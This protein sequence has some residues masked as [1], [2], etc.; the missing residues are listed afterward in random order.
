MLDRG[1]ELYERKLPPGE[2]V[3]PGL[4]FPLPVHPQSPQ[5]GDSWAPRGSPPTR[6]ARVAAGLGRTAGAVPPPLYSFDPATGRL[7]VTTPRYNT[8]I[9]AVTHGA[10][11]YGGIDLARLFDDRQNVAATLGAKPPSSFGVI[12]R[13]RRGRARLVTARP[14]SDLYKKPALRLVRAPL[15]VGSAGSPL[16]PFAG[17]STGSRC[18]ARRQARGRRGPLDLHL[19]PQ[20]DRRRVVAAL[21][22]E[23]APSAEV[24]FPSTGGDKAAVW[25]ILKGGT[26]IQ[27]T[28]PRPHAGHQPGSGSQSEDSG[29]AVV[30][31]RPRQG[32]DPS[33]SSSPIRRP[34]RR[35]RARRSWC[36]SRTACAR[37]ARCASRSRSPS[38]GAADAAKRAAR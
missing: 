4:F 21:A 2:G 34:R 26:V 15:G 20:R 23:P 33:R 31:R 1:F 7:A 12:V 16:R 35:T 10:Y 6:P 36:A 18:A 32:L 3:A 30:P 19:P 5:A 14:A 11:P 13:N 9:T 24:Q 29:Y 27:L 22:D 38:R 8:A 25:A 17:R 37:S 28:G